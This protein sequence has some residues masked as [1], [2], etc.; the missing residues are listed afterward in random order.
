MKAK[1][2]TEVLLNSDTIVDGFGGHVTL[3]SIGLYMSGSA[4]RLS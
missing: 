4:L 3:L 2:Q 1:R